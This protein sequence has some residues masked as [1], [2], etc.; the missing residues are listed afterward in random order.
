[1]HTGAP[2][3]PGRTGKGV[4]VGIIDSGIAWKHP[5]FLTGT[6]NAKR[7]RILRIWDQSLGAV[8]GEAP[9][10]GFT[11]GVEYSQQQ[12][13]SALNGAGAVVRHQPVN[14]HGTHVAGIAAGN[15]GGTPT[16]PLRR[17]RAVRLQQLL[18]GLW[19]CAIGGSA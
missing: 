15:G 11:Y 8:T 16:T 18:Q 12:I 7:S 19:Q 3:K 10:A 5:S 14:P 9:P 2:G 13:T 4:I 6:G 1:M 17:G